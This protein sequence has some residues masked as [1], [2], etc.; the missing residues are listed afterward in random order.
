MADADPK[1]SA[2]KKLK[3]AELSR[4]TGVPKSTILY[5]L[6]QGLLP[7]P[8]RPKPNVALYDPICVELLGYIRSAQEIHRY[9]VKWIEANVKNI[10]D[11][12]PAE[13]FLRLGRR[14]FGD[15]THSYSRAEVVD[16]VGIDDA[17][18]DRYINVGLV[19]PM[20]GSSEQFDEY[21][22][23]QI[24]LLANVQR[25]G[26]PPEEFLEAAEA[27]KMFDLATANLVRR[28]VPRPM[29]IALATQLFDLFEHFQP[30]L[31][32]RFVEERPPL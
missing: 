6:G 4:V 21:D 30:Y 17:N 16:K 32:H 14:I 23:K 11:G 26:I 7:E 8:E 9:P 10:M 12:T 31:M 29:D 1:Q 19:F 27:I 22:L 3:M 13:K 15:A 20:K 2:K 25:S 24:E 18:L 28:W 5:Y